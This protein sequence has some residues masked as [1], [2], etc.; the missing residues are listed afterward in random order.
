[1]E[2]SRVVEASDNYI[3]AHAHSESSY[4]HVH[5]VLDA[6]EFTVGQAVEKALSELYV[7]SNVIYLAEYKRRPSQPPLNAS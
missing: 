1:M 4:A 3:D 6:F 2:K 5:R 7:P